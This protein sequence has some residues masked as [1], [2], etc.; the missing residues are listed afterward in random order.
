MNFD[1]EVEEGHDT[2]RMENKINEYI[3]VP[4][5]SLKQQDIM[6]CVEALI[7]ENK[8]AEA[9]ETLWDMYKA[10]Q[11][12]E[13]SG[14]VGRYILIRI[15]HINIYNE[16]YIAARHNLSY[17]MHFPIT[18]GNPLLHLRLGQVQDKLGN[19]KRAVDEL[20]RALIMDGKR[21]FD[22]EDRRLLEIPLRALNESMDSEWKH[23]EGQ[24]WE[25]TK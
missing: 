9:I 1:A 12:R 19:E 11:R 23:Y 2:N 25:V 4:K 7:R 24:D 10:L 15:A 22:Q 16:D 14:N 3:S 17:V 8:F 18:I 20:A 5:L 13:Q 21:V 6:A